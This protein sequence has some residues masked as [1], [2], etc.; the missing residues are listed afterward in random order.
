MDDKALQ[1][2]KMLANPVGLVPELDRNESQNG[3]FLPPPNCEDVPRSVRLSVRCTVEAH[4]W[5]VGLAE[6]CSLD[7]TQIIWQSLLRQA[8]SSGF[9][10]KIP[11]RYRKKVHPNRRPSAL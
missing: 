8:E 11:Q 5:V 10:T 7:V 2:A 9:Y 4:S 3:V 6:H 1:R